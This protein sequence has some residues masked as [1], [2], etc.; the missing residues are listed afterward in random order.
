MH[1]GGDLHLTACIVDYLTNRPQYVNTWV[2]V[3]DMVVCSTGGPGRHVLVPFLFTP[4]T[5]D[6]TKSPPSCHLQKFFDDSPIVGL[7]TE[8]DDGEHSGLIEDFVDW[9]LWN[10]LH[11]NAGKPK[12][13]WWISAGGN[14]PL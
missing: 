2:C 8:D 13:W 3:S 1:A 10:C 5:A 11:I 9:C 4:Y 14:T 6:L 7:I 12:K